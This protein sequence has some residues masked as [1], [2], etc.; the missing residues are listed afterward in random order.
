MG[1]TPHQK[2]R[3]QSRILTRLKIKVD[4]RI[5]AVFKIQSAF[6]NSE[7][8][9]IC[10]NRVHKNT[11]LDCGHCFHHKCLNKWITSGNNNNCPICRAKLSICNEVKLAFYLKAMKEL[12]QLRSTIDE[13][14][15]E[16][17]DDYD[18]NTFKR[19]YAIAKFISGALYGVIHN[20]YGCSKWMRSIVNGN[21]VN[22]MME[23]LVDYKIELKSDIEM[24]RGDILVANA[25]INDDD[26]DSFID[27]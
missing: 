15:P 23:M 16:W 5:D 9:A 1:I 21:K 20:T 17:L 4:K 13:L 27:L 11:V 7:E 10:F 2:M 3:L 8:C 26:D 24:I 14:D 12:E 19:R 22:E 18:K 6:K 25:L